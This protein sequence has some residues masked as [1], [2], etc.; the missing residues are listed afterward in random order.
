MEGPR[1]VQSAPPGR[2]LRQRCGAPAENA[3]FFRSAAARQ[4]AGAA[5]LEAAP[6]GPFNGVRP[7]GRPIAHFT[8]CDILK[9]GRRIEA[10]MNAT[11]PPMRMIISGSIALVTALIWAFSW[12][13]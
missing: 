5:P 6:A 12:A 3:R 9:I 13:S 4:T 11:T 2:F 8:N 7:G 1:V 10:A